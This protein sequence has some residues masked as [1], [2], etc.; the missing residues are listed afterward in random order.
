MLD[1]A[2]ALGIERPNI[3]GWSSGGNVGLVLAAVHGDRV[4]KVA[5]LAGMAGGENTSEW[6]VSW[7]LSGQRQAAGR[8]GCSAPAQPLPAASSANALGSGVCQLTSLRICLPAWRCLSFAC[9]HVQSCPLPTRC[10][11]QISTCL[12]A[13]RWPSSSPRTCLVGPTDRCRHCPAALHCEATRP[14]Y[15]LLLLILPL[16]WLPLPLSPL[17]PSPWACRL[18][19][20]LRRLHQGRLLHAWGHHQPRGGRPRSPGAVGGRPALYHRR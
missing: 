13:T 14:P 3:L 2:A 20:H 11:I 10:S 18:Q 6:A 1:L 5:S 16:P 15:S 4:G 12:W 17:P 7:A 8:G 19:G 9:S